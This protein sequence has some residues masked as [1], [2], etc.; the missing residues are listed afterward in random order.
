MYNS[1]NLQLLFWLNL[2]KR[3][4]KVAPI[5]VRI[6][7]EGERTE[8]SL[9][10][11][12][13]IKRWNKKTRR[14]LD[15]SSSDV[16]LNNFLNLTEQKLHS[17]YTS[18][19]NEFDFVSPLMVK[20]QFLGKE[21][22][23]RTLLQLMEYHNENMKG[24]LKDGTLKNYYTTKKYLSYFLKQKYKTKDVALK[25][26]RYS[27]I[28]DFEQFLRS[29][30]PL[31]ISNTLNNN[32]IMK[33][34]ERI[35]K[36]M[37]LAT[38]LEWL[39]KN[40][41]KRYKLKFNKHRSAYLTEFELAAMEN[42]CFDNKILDLIRDVFIFSCYT[43]LSYSDVK[44]LN[45]QNIVKGIDGKFWIFSKRSKN[46]QP[47]RIPLMENAIRIIEKYKKSFQV[48]TDYLLPVYSNQKVNFHLK[49]IAQELKINKRI[50]FHSARHTFATT[51]TLS[52]GVPIETVSKMLGHTKITTT[53]LYARVL[54]E[55][56]GK[57]MDV[58]MR[59]MVSN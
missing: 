28:I 18:L 4:G 33:H 14:V 57:D 20:N 11:N 44:K 39:D 12:A 23:N 58:L 54:E 8:V 26:L 35:K 36:L 34:L 59:K 22:K 31:Q 49:E 16:E 46:A 41:F 43:G 3:N 25:Q 19:C 40:P 15:E 13:F 50:T 27:F 17:I 37:N 32:G 51:V 9:K 55:K 47:L 45:A 2:A 21:L 6:T 56:I 52:N 42:Y 38:D 1:Q 29:A 48:Q 24:S 30:K 10:K 5:Y 7:I 53:Q